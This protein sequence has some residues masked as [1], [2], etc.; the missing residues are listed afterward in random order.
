MLKKYI[1]NNNS[2]FLNFILHFLRIL[3]AVSRESIKFAP[4]TINYLFKIKGKFGFGVIQI[5]LGF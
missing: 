5:F 1:S 2:Y 4:V 3:T